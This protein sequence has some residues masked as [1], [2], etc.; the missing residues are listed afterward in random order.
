MGTSTYT[1]KKQS[2]N[3]N[4][5]IIKL[6]TDENKMINCLNDLSKAITDL[7]ADLQNLH[8]TQQQTNNKI[9]YMLIAAALLLMVFT[10]SLYLQ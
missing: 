4:N 6:T 2:E 10:G 9:D 5:N 3:I 8:Q 1:N 7:K